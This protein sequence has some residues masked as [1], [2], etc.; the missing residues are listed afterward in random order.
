MEPLE[1]DDEGGSDSSEDDVESTDLEEA[2]SASGRKGKG[3][4]KG[5]DRGKD[6]GKGTGKG[7]GTSKSKGKEKTSEPKPKPKQKKKATPRVR[8]G[9]GKT[10]EVCEAEPE[11]RLAHAPDEATPSVEAGPSKLAEG[12]DFVPAG[13]EFC[14]E[15]SSEGP[16]VTPPGLPR[17]V[18]GLEKLVPQFLGKDYGIMDEL[19]SD[20]DADL[21]ALKMSYRPDMTRYIKLELGRARLHFKALS[22]MQAGESDATNQ[23]KKRADVLTTLLEAYENQTQASTDY[24]N[25]S[26]IVSESVDKDGNVSMGAADEAG[27]QLDFIFEADEG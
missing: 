11:S 2:A 15:S 18:A 25:P 9:K 21:A 3:K 6:K 5:K 22:R 10:K 19:D 14:P 12:D 16:P 1:G 8:G 24:E 4:G 20:E 26:V 27:E 7:K 23:L 13:D 17:S